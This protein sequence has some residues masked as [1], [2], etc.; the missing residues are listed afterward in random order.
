MNSQRFEYKYLIGE[1]QAGAVRAF[2]LAHLCA[3]S[4]TDAAHNNEYPVQSVYLDT[5]DMSLYY[6]TVTGER[7]RFKLRVRSYDPCAHAPAFLEIKARKNEAV[8]KERAPVHKGALGRIVG[9]FCTMRGDLSDSSAAHVGALDRF[10]ELCARL[11]ARPRV[12]VR[13]RREAYVD[14]DGGPLRVTMD[15]DV[16][17]AH[18]NGPVV[19]PDALEWVALAGESVVLEIKFT[20]TF[21]RWAREMVQAL[22]LVRTSAAKYVRSVDALVD[23]G[24]GLA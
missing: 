13:Y 11:S 3:D 18:T 4:H 5:A 21:P 22:G 24:M 19:D 7:N 2:A 14:P 23:A 9:S 1:S 8:L 10:C 20:D 17:C 16:A 12:V 6:E 15:R